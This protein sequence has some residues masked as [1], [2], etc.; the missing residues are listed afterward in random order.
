V[1]QPEMERVYMELAKKW[2]SQNTWNPIDK[3]DEQKE[4][5]SGDKD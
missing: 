4:F 2:N 5:I 3:E 1:E